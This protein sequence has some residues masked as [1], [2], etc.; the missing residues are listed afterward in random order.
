MSRVYL[1]PPDMD[2]DEIEAVREAFESGWIT[3]LGPAVRAFERDMCERIGCRHALALSSGT[4][5][6]HLAV[7][8]LEVGRGDRVLCSSLTFVATATPIL[9][10]RATPVFIDSERDSWNLDPDLLE[11]ELA[12]SSAA[13]ERPAAV[14]VADIFGQCAHYG[15]IER[16]C[17]E[18][19]VPLIEDAAEALG[20]ECEGEPAGRFGRCAVFSFNG[21]KIITTSGGG[22]LVSDDGAL[23]ERAR[24]LSTQARDPAPHYEHSDYG[25]NYRMSNLLAALGSAQLAR[26]DRRVARRREIFEAY[27]AGLDDLAGVEFMPQPPWSRSNR[28]LTCV[29]LD[30]DAFGAD[31]EQVRT[32]LEAENL[33]ARPLWKPLHLQPVFADAPRVGG[34]VAEDLFARGL[35]LPSGSRM[36]PAEQQRVIETVRAAA[37]P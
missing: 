17:R 29:V 15:R 19:E 14:I 9:Y 10:Q 35:C 2:G 12:R 21:N 22:M 37:R 20:A 36:T 1:S 33:E 23:V 7:R 8:C 25:Y 5:A 34:A 32:A 16:I 11:Q 4:A 28:W 3:S 27:V 26:L 30:P 31:R 6:L 24:H 18:Y 13:N